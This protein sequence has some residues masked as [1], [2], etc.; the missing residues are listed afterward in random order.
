MVDLDIPPVSMAALAL[1]SMADLIHQVTSDHHHML[2]CT[3]RRSLTMWPCSQG[4]AKC[5]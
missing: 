2:A 4:A 1:C 5:M 3:L